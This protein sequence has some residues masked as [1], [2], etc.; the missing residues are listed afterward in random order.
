MSVVLNDEFGLRYGESEKEVH[1]LPFQ[2]TIKDKEI[3]LVD[4]SQN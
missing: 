2:V 4:R 3:L 1:P